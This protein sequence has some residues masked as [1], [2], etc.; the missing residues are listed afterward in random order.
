[1][2]PPS[3][4]ISFAEKCWFSFRSTYLFVINVVDFFVACMLLSF[5][6]YLWNKLGNSWSSP[7]T[8]WLLWC[9]VIIS[10]LLLLISGFSFIAMASASCRFLANFTDYLAIIV[11]LFDLAVGVAAFKLQSLVLNFISD[12]QEN[13]ALTDQDVHMI[14]AWYQVLAFGFFVSLFLESLRVFCNAGFSKT[15]ARMDNEYAALMAEEDRK[16]EES[17]SERS[18]MTTEKYSALRKYYRQ[19]YAR[20]DRPSEEM[21][22]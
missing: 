10:V 8:S 12:N 15:A 6:I 1:M 5:A 4:K 7:Q 14:K 17:S 13:M 16:W 11:V 21:K 20:E 22:V 2:P 19:K 9:C 3:A 18:H